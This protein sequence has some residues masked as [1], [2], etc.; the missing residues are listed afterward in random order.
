MV[1]RRHLGQSTDQGWPRH[2]V[3]NAWPS[4]VRWGAERTSNGPAI[5]LGVRCES[6]ELRRDVGQ[7]AGRRRF[8]LAMSSGARRAAALIATSRG[9]SISSARAPT[10]RPS[11]GGPR[12]ERRSCGARSMGKPWSGA[13]RRGN[14]R[15]GNR[16]QRSEL[17]HHL[18]S[19]VSNMSTEPTSSLAPCARRV[20]QSRGR[21]ERGAVDMDFAVDAGESLRLVGDRGRRR[22]HS[23]PGSRP[24]F[25][26]RPS[27]RSCSS[28]PV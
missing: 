28:C 24:A 26:I 22:P 12:M 7:M 2:R 5:E 25:P 14:G 4:G 16:L 1:W 6:D 15:V 20:E 17:R 3:A 9:R 8:R 19:A 13:P 27:L 10:E 11:S 18:G 23:L 21:Q